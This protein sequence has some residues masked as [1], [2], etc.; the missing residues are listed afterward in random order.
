MK[1]LRLREELSIG[2]GSGLA[3]PSS[4]KFV[5]SSVRVCCIE[6]SSGFSV[7]PGMVGP[8]FPQTRSIASYKGFERQK[9]SHNWGITD[10]LQ[11]AYFRSHHARRKLIQ[12]NS[13][14]DPEP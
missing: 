9:L 5:L 12:I 6:G 8:T 14:R 11:T 7:S 2:S 3:G 13:Q 1:P 10:A 4:V